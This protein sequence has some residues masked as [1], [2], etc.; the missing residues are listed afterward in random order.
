ML[1]IISWTVS[2]DA[3]TQPTSQTIRHLRRQSSNQSAPTMLTTVAC[4]RT[5]PPSAGTRSTSTRRPLKA[6]NS[7]QSTSD[8][9]TRPAPC[10]TMARPSAGAMTNSA[11]HRHE[12]NCAGLL[13][14]ITQ[15]ANQQLPVPDMDP[16]RNRAVGSRLCFRH[17]WLRISVAAN[18]SSSLDQISPVPSGSL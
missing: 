12:A 10:V 15:R 7:D 4:A 3:G 1:F 6:R 13:G 18:R 9:S 16:T 17:I 14:G 8:G 5:G 11:R 2:G